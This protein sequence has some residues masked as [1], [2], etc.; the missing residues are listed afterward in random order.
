MD[1]DDGHEHHEAVHGRATT[2]M[3]VRKQCVGELDRE[4]TLYEVR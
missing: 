4:L 2:E 1:G 3:S